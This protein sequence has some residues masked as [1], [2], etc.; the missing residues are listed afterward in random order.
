MGLGSGLGLEAA[1]DRRERVLPEHEHGVGQSDGDV[2]AADEREVGEREH[3][4]RVRVGAGVGV[5]AR[6]RVSVRARVR[7]RV[8]GEC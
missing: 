6:V 7:L 3:L 2:P 1:C 5:R 8:N 4:V